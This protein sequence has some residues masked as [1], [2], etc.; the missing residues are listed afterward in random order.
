MKN[1]GDIKMH[2]ATIKKYVAISNLSRHMAMR[3]PVC[4][5]DD[6]GGFEMCVMLST[7]DKE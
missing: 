3:S 4:T 2:G 6:V 5:L 1:L 7:D